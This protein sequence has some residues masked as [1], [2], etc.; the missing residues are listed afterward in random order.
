MNIYIFTIQQI[1]SDDLIQS[2]LMIDFSLPRGVYRFQWVS[3][4]FRF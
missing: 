4:R 3:Y 1:V 2:D